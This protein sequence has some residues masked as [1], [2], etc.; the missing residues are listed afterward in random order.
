V[1]VI[2]TELAVFKLINGQFTLTE[3]MPGASLE[4]VRTATT[5][6]FVEALG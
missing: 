6:A 1:D 3:L 5:A 4:Q 2:I